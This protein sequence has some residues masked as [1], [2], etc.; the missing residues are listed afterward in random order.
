M[1]DFTR[2]FPINRRF[3]AIVA[4]TTPAKSGSLRSRLAASTIALIVVSTES[5]AADDMALTKAPSAYATPIYDS[6][7]GRPWRYF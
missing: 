1:P 6:D 2:T 7:G 3:R 5:A 4:K